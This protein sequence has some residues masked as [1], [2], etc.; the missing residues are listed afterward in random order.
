MVT[1]AEYT[2]ILWLQK[3]KEFIVNMKNFLYIVAVIFAFANYHQV[4][5]TEQGK[6]SSDTT[7]ILSALFSICT[8][9]SYQ[10]FSNFYDHSIK[11]LCSLN[12]RINEGFL[13][14]NSWQ[15]NKAFQLG[16][17]RVLQTSKQRNRFACSVKNDIDNLAWEQLSI[18]TFKSKLRFSFN[19]FCA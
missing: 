5:A 12:V 16:N 6:K 1:S 13:A 9:F 2:V 8:D 4:K 3:K 11:I 10:Y 7:F 14:H 17:I 18:G 19:F 15:L